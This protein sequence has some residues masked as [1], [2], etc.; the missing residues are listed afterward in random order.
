M[1][2]GKDSSI[3]DIEVVKRYLLQLQKNICD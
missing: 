3:P 2:T 1:S